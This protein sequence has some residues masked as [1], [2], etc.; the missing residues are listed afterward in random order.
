MQ[1]AANECDSVY[2][3]LGHGVA[4]DRGSMAKR[5][6]ASNPRRVGH[7]ASGSTEAP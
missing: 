2:R 5:W 6:Q 7:G 3:S 1:F 4:L